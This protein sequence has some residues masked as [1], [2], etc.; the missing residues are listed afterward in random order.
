MLTATRRTVFLDDDGR[1]DVL[2]PLASKLQLVETSHRY[3]IAPFFDALIRPPRS[4][5]I[6]ARY[7][8]VSRE[9]ESE[10][11]RERAHCRACTGAVLEYWLA[12][13]QRLFQLPV[14][15]Q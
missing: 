8:L 7:V 13:Q 2:E 14:H 15:I 5:L 6:E 9:R 4:D 3:F 12:L 11:E 1:H 10:R